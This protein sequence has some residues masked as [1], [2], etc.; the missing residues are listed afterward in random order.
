LANVAGAFGCRQRF[1][2]IFFAPAKQV[3]RFSLFQHHS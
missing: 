2:Q 3:K 1:H